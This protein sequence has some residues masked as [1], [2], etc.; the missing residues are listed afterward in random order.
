MILDQVRAEALDRGIPAGD[1]ERWMRLVRPC[2]LLTQGGDGPVVGRFG[3][4]V[5]LPADVA[6][7]RFPLLVTIE[8]SALPAGVT[9]LPL[10]SDGKLLLFG[11]P[12][13]EGSYSMGDVVYVPEGAVTTERPEYPEGYPP[14]PDSYLGVYESLPDGEVRLTVDVSLPFV[15]VVELPEAPWMA[16]LPGHPHAEE[17]AAVWADQWGGAQ[18]LLGGYGTEHSDFAPAATIAS[19]AVDA[20]KEGHRSGTSSPRA[21]DWVL[22]AEVNVDRP[23][24]GAT[25][26]WGIQREDLAAQR[27]DRAHVAVYWNP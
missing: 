3:G 22:L 25:I 12:E 13:P 10:P 19:F 2:A 15:G 11:F 9:D 6:D 1:V 27:F 21:E 17:L 24:A 23:G 26:Y 14:D 18:L 4:P 20:E 7:P 16:P 5:R 8:C